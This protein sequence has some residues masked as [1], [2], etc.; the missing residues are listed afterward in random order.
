LDIE[1]VCPS[2]GP[3]YRSPRRSQSERGRDR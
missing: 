3:G 1:Y 2:S